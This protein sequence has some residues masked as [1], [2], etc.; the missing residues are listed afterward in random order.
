MLRAAAARPSVPL[1]AAPTS[2]PHSY[3]ENY[4][5]ERDYAHKQLQ[6]HP[7][8]AEATA[9]LASLASAGAKVDVLWW[10]WCGT[11]AAGTADS[12]LP[13]AVPSVTVT[14]PFATASVSAASSR[15]VRRLRTA[16]SRQQ[17]RR[18]SLRGQGSLP[19]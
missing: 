6:L 15:S 14:R 7:H 10:V 5:P 2:F 4:D 19:S 13:A 1:H 9:S 17:S 3:D 16:A 8:L 12:L 18:G 11:V